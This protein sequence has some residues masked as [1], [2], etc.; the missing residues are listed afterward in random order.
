MNDLRPQTKILNIFKEDTPRN[1]EF[2]ELCEQQNIKLI[3][4]SD[5][6]KLKE[7]SIEHKPEI[8]IVEERLISDRKIFKIKEGHYDPFK[9]IVLDNNDYEKS[10]E[11]IKEG[12]DDVINTNYIVEEIFLKCYSQLRRK[13]SLEENLMTNLPS[14]NKT[15]KLIEHCL[16]NINDWNLTHISMSN[17]KSYNQVYGINRGDQAIKALSRF[18]R[19]SIKGDAFLGHLGSDNFIILSESNAENCIETIKKEFDKKLSELYEE[20]DYKN[21]FIISSGPTKIRRR[22]SLL[23]LKIGT[24]SSNER[25]FISSTDVIEQAIKNKKKKEAAN[26]KVLILEDDEDFSDLLSDTLGYEGLESKISSGLE[27]LINEL[28]EFK[29]KILVLEA[30]KLKKDSFQELSTKLIKFKQEFGLKILVATNIPGHRSFLEAGADVYIPKP[31]DLEV[32]FREI[33]RLRYL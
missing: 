10:L 22:V 9:M 31:Y 32:L 27:N 14:I 16:E 6:S 21:S 23:K 33:R 19:S 29:P 13:K 25:K 2:K 30:A 18:L 5:Y 28:E 8:I 17:F 11:Y 15:H 3:A 20:E 24:C 7:L 12:I 4:T 1:Q 26:K